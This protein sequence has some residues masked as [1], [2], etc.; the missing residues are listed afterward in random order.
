M[1]KDYLRL[2]VL[3]CKR[4]KKE[5]KAIF[6]IVI[7]GSFTRGKK[8]LRDIDMMIIFRDTKLKE[9]LEI[10][11]RFKSEIKK[12]VDDLD[13]KTMNLDDFFDETLLA[14]QGVL[15]EG[16]SLVKNKPLAELLG[17][18]GYVIFT[19]N[20]KNLDH[21]KKTQFTYALSGRNTEGVLKSV[22]GVSL[23]RGAV[24]IPIEN[25]E[26]FEEFLEKWGI[27]YSMKKALISR[28]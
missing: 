27:E 21:N 4:F 14:R 2:L 26:E 9:R 22:K 10:A 15:I 18:N 7:Y 6:D 1:Q 3:N 13:V 12:K 16:Y 17:L 11:Q 28:A 19:Y 20:L 24:Q 23:G 25:S 5:N 8:G